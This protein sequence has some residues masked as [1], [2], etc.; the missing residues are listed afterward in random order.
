MC[1]ILHSYIIDSCNHRCVMLAC[2]GL[3]FDRR[4]HHNSSTSRS[5]FNHF[6]CFKCYHWRI[7][8]LCHTQSQTKRLFLSSVFLETMGPLY[9]LLDWFSFNYLRSF[10]TCFIWLW[11]LV[12]V[13]KKMWPNVAW[14]VNK[15]KQKFLYF[16]LFHMSQCITIT[17]EIATFFFQCLVCWYKKKQKIKKINDSC[18]W[19][20]NEYKCALPCYSNLTSMTCTSTTENIDCVCVHDSQETMAHLAPMGIAITICCTWIGFAFFVFGSL[21]NANIVEKLKEAVR[22]FKALRSG[23]NVDEDDY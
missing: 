5:T 20:S 3:T 17:R 11:C 21:W 16:I 14:W 8:R 23:E 9:T 6:N 19:S 12:I 10:K 4:N 18:N 15:T 13:S 1:G 7:M 2:A 22:Q